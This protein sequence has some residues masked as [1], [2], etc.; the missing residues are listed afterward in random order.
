MVQEEPYG[1]LFSPDGRW[2]WD[3]QRWLPAFS[4]DMKW[5][6]DG[7]AWRRVNSW[8]R[9]P[10]WALIPGLIWMFMLAAWMP[11]AL[12]LAPPSQGLGPN[13]VAVILPLV[14]GAMLVTATIGFMVGRWWQLRGIWIAAALGAGAQLF[15]YVVAMLDSPQPDGVEDIAAGAGVAILGLPTTLAIAAL[16]WLGAGLGLA[17]RAVHRRRTLEQ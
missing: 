5:R 6:F 4:P 12:V 17:I 10:T 7:H 14:A 2:W 9:P 3:G 11:V 8:R 1:A 13:A 15:G 16:L